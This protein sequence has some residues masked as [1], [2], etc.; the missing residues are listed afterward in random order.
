MTAAQCYLLLI[1]TNSNHNKLIINRYIFKNIV[2]SLGLIKTNQALIR[3]FTD[4][5]RSIFSLTY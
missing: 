4:V 1:G 5:I 2:Q 3:A